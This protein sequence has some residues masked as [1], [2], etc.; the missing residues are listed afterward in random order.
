MRKF[1]GGWRECE[2]PREGKNLKLQLLDLWEVNPEK[3]GELKMAEKKKTDENKKVIWFRAKEYG[4]GWYPVTW[5]GWVLTLGFIAI[6]VGGATFAASTTNTAFTLIFF[7]FMGVFL[8]IFI[9]ICYATGEKPE[10][11]WGGKPIFKKK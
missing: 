9:F 10:W 7:P 11:R 1:M 6:A 3:N 5:E 4:W 2:T 8:L